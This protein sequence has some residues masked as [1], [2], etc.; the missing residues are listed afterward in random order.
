MKNQ[1]VTVVGGSGFVGRHVVH[2]LA[3]RGYRIRVLVRDTIA[4]EF[5]KTQGSVGQIAIEHADL[6]RPE[7]LRGKLDESVAVVSLV[8]IMY[9]TGR[10][11]FQN[12]NVNGARAI[13]DEATRAGVATLVHVSALGVDRARDTRYGATKLTGEQVVRAGF[14]NATILRPSLI[15]GPEDKFFQRFARMSMF[16]PA[17]PLIGGGTTKFQPVLVTDVAS[18]VLACIETPAARGLTYELGGPKT[19]SFK[20]LL[21]LI[22]TTINR[23]PLLLSL[24]VGIAKLQGLLCELLPFPPMLTRDQ[25]GLLA[26]DNVMSVGAKTF[27]DL[28]LKATALETALPALLARYVKE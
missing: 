18:A 23:H 5:L 3:S 11:K 10:Q 13:A 22:G 19:Y 4:A 17:L 6:T 28:G 2:L 1:L 16:A 8:S 7:T 15:A 27:V 20:E 21:E 26:H 14:P 24:P 25:V 9:E 12:I